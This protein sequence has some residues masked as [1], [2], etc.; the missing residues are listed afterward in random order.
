M[1]A[2]VGSI[3][4]SPHHLSVETLDGYVFPAPL[5]LALLAALGFIRS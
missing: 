3:F 4:L 5:A 2:D 1:E